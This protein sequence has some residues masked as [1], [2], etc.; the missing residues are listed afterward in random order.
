M[1]SREE[2]LAIYQAGPDAMVALVEQLL[3]HQAMLEQHVTGLTM[4]VT[5][6]EARLNKDSHNSHKPPSRDGPAKRPRP[7][8]LRKR[9]GKQSGGQT[10]HPG[11]TRALVDDPDVV[12]RHPPSAC[13]GCG[14]SLTIAPE[15]QR[16]RRQVIELPK[17]RPEVTEHQTLQKTCPVCQTVTVGEFPPDVTQPI[18]YG[19]RTKAVAVYL[20][21]YQLLSYERTV[22]ALR[23][24]FGVA[25]SEGTLATAQQTAAIHLAPV[26]QAIQNALR[27]AEVAHVDE[28]GVRVANHTEW[29][30]VMSTTALTV[31]AHHAKRGRQAFEA[32]GLLIGFRG[33]RMHDAWAPY[34]NLAGLYAL[35]NAH[36]LRELIGLHEETGQAWMQK[37]I[38]LLL[39]MK[40]AVADARAAG[41][42][43]L[44]PHQCAGYEAAYT[45]YLN[46]AGRAN[47]PPKPTG[48][49]GRPKQTPARNLLD[50]LETHRAAILTFVHDF[51]VP[52][53]NNQAERDLRMLKVKHKVSGCFRSPDG[54]DA[55]CRIRGYIS[56]LRKQGYSVLDGLT[57]VFAGQP[58]MPRLAA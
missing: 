46:E 17:P 34:L 13:A 11:V 47:P 33:R 5:E 20:Q 44:S 27:Q 37:L 35:C 41:Q 42:I 45:R 29:V 23:D 49:R 57:S 16:E 4:R 39:R 14:V 12:V 24:L 28:T 30:H 38:I 31:Y 3:V 40:A 56:T 15:V 26:E 58:Y 54:A 32:I 50:R 53:D 6:L 36:L 18:Q 22:E 7:R 9:S 21:T 19:P 25:P 48:Q 2:I 55:F 8:S 52:F 1:L 10:G 51:R 43:T